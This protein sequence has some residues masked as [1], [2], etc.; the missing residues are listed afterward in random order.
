MIQLKPGISDR[1][2]IKDARSVHA[3]A[4][5]ARLLERNGPA[6]ISSA[7]SAMENARLRRGRMGTVAPPRSPTTAGKLSFK[8][9]NIE[10][11]ANWSAL[12][13]KI[14]VSKYFYGDIANGTDPEQGR[15]RNIGRQLI[16]R[17]T[18]TIADW[19]LLDGY[20]ADTQTAET[21]LR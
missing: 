16:H 20:F 6:C 13:T 9:D 15:T 4:L 11:P 17:V 3:R 18:R 5:V 7:F 12:A 1:N 2:S 10:V 21:F 19:G 14:A 8:Q